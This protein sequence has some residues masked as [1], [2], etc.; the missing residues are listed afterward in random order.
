[1]HVGDPCT[2]GLECNNVCNEAANNCAVA[3]NTAC[4]DDGNGCTDDQ[5]DGAGACVHPNNFAPCDDGLFCNGQDFCSGGS[6]DFHQG[7]PCLFS[8][9]CNTVC[10]EMSDMCTPTM[11]GAPCSDDGTVCTNDQC[12]G[13]GA[14]AHPPVASGL[15]CPSDGNECTNDQCNGAGVCGHPPVA[16]T[17]PCTDDGND[18]TDDKCNGAGACG[19]PARMNGTSCNDGNACTHSDQCQSGICVGASPMACQP[20]QCR[21]AGTCDPDSGTCSSCPAGY[22]QGNGGCTKTYAMN[23]SALDNLNSFCDG[24]GVNLYNGCNGSPF[25]FHWTDTANASV[26]AV[27]RVDVQLEAGVDCT[28]N[29]H[30]VTLNAANIGSYQ[31]SGDCGCIPVHAPHLLANVASG[32]YVKGGANAVAITPLSCT[33]LSQDSGGSYAVVTVTYQAPTLPYAIRSGCR[34]AAKSKL[35]YKSNADDTKDK[36]KWK[37]GKGPGTTAAEFGDPTASTQYQLCVYATTSGAP[38]LLFDATVPGSSSLWS[39]VGTNGYK[40]NDVAAGAEGASRILLRA[41]A[42]GKPKILIKGKGTGLTDP[43]LPLAM[44][45]TG[46]RVQL[47]N[48]SNG[49]CWESDFPLNNVTS[50]DHSIKAK[51]P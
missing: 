9:E 21:A 39:T 11:V 10:N 18:C 15:P 29:T 31:G 48:E 25:G 22:A 13:A 24:T 12:D 49:L 41:G 34:A 8:S 6:C 4:T 43:T 46:V 36:L 19:H 38:T 33:G 40:Y 47:N 26:G 32:S 35:T 20:Q 50:D 42:D 51:A 16:N 27:T 37:W 2:G 3:A 1:V 7:D 28:T 44:G 5:C 23:T 17:V 30:A 14:C 45:T